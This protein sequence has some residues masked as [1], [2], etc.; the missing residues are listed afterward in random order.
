MFLD[1]KGHLDSIKRGLLVATKNIIGGL[2]SKQEIH[3]NVCNIDRYMHFA[4][5]GDIVMA[6]GKI[7]GKTP[8]GLETVLDKYPLMEPIH[9]SVLDN[10]LMAVF[11]DYNQKRPRKV[12]KN[13]NN[14]LWETCYQELVVYTKKQ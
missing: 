11:S 2:I 5:R 12:P 14:E 4:T 10:Y 1:K 9:E 6:K 3:H 13:S 8:Y 7:N